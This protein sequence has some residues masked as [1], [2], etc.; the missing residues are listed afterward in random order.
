MRYLKYLIFYICIFLSISEI[1]SKMFLICL[2]INFVE[3]IFYSSTAIYSFG[4][5]LKKEMSFCLP[6]TISHFT[7]HLL[8]RRY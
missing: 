6:H 5:G 7:V 3:F 1:I 8:A 2:Y 4:G